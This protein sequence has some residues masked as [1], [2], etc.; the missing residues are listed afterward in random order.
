MR[1]VVR[2]PAAGVLVAALV[3]ILASSASAHEEI[4]PA[5]VPTGRPTFLTLSAANEQG[6][7]LTRVTLRAPAGVAFGVAT[8][9]PQGWAP[10]RSPSTI[11]WSGG[12]VANSSFGEWGFEIEAVAQPGPLRFTVELGYSDGSTDDSQVEVIAEGA[13]VVTAPPSTT[14][15]EAPGAT[16]TVP[17]AA[18]DSDSGEGLATAALVVA[19]IAA[20][21]SLLAIALAVRRRPAVLAGA[22]G[23]A[24]PP[25]S[26][27]KEDQDW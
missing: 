18:E 21:L 6:S 14:A 5:T 23:A 7:D 27:P 26:N 11:T 17:A 1:T 9:Q 22:P 16:T 15:P 24:V 8:Q 10:A 12:T 3:L 20:V 25:A 2:A 19:V 13:P 4:T